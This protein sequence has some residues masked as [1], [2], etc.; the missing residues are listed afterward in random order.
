MSIRLTRIGSSSS[1]RTTGRSLL[2][3]A[4]QT[5]SPLCRQFPGSIPPAASPAPRRRASSSTRSSIPRRTLANPDL[6]RSHAPCNVFATRP[7]SRRRR[8]PPWLRPPDRRRPSRSAPRLSGG[9]A[10]PGSGSSCPSVV[11]RSAVCEFRSGFAPRARRAQHPG[12]KSDPHRPSSNP[13]SSIL[14]SCLPTISLP[15]MMLANGFVVKRESAA[16]SGGPD[17][18]EILVASL[19]VVAGRT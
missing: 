14:P 2:A 3:R 19:D 7:R 1:A 4:A 12:R 15:S 11:A 6:I 5:A 9:A 13:P 17:C 16:T 10:V 8:P 18:L